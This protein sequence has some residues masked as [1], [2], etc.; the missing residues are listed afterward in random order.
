VGTK[1]NASSFWDGVAR[2][3]RAQPNATTADRGTLIHTVQE[4][5]KKMIDEQGRLVICVQAISK[6]GFEL[7][8][9]PYALAITL[10]LGQ[11][12]RSQ[13]YAEVEQSIRTRTRTRV[14]T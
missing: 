5:T 9:V 6:L 10:E 2:T 11:Q 1:K 4:G 7:Q 3:R 14:G 12:A 13:L 8:D